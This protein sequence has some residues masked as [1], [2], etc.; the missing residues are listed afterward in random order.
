MSVRCPLQRGQVDM[1][2]RVADSIAAAG[3]AAGQGSGDG[4]WRVFAYHTRRGHV[5]TF[6]RI[7]ASV[8]LA[9]GVVLVFAGLSA[10]LGLTTLGVLGS[11]AA[12]AAL[13]YAGAVW[14]G[15]GTIPQ[16]AARLPI[17][18]FDRSGRIVAGEA[19]G[20][21]VS[22]QFPEMLRP[23]IERRCRA[24]LGG[25]SERFPCLHNG[26]MVVFDAVP[27]RRAD[28]AVVYGILLRTE[29]EPAAIAASL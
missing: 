29:A 5:A 9:V 7:L 1:P 17:V 12:I 18:V 11:A 26:R 13:L 2:A 16:A 15:A 3:T 19:A 25:V 20:E 24:A 4:P 23:E 14:F 27:V 22:S 28:G 10:S 8:L 21:S 6:K